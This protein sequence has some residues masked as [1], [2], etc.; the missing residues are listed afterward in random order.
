MFA[1]LERVRK[2]ITFAYQVRRVLTQSAGPYEDG[3]AKA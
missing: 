2:Q 3:L 1:E